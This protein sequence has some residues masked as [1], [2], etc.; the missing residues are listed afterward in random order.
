MAVVGGFL[1][2][3]IGAFLIWIALMGRFTKIGNKIFNRMDKTFG[4]SKGDNKQ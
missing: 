4:E 3:L 2:I 1:L